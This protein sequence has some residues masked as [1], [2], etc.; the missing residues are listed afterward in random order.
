MITVESKV[1]PIKKNN[2]KS[3]LKKIIC[4]LF[5]VILA[6]IAGIWFLGEPQVHI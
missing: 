4:I 6:A 1:N 5:L 3:G 2:Q